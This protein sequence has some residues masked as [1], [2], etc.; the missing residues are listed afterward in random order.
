MVLQMGNKGFEKAETFSLSLLSYWSEKEL[1]FLNGFEIR[2]SLSLAFLPVH[3]SFLYTCLALLFH[4]LALCGGTKMNEQWKCTQS[5][6]KRERE[7]TREW[8]RK[9]KFQNS[10]L[11]LIST[12]KVMKRV[13]NSRFPFGIWRTWD[14]SWFCEASKRPLYRVYHSHAHRFSFHWFSLLNRE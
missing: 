5:K 1:L 3:L 7:A 4:I 10:K 12:G 8:V 14:F 13:S 2:F 11:S 9:K 6:G